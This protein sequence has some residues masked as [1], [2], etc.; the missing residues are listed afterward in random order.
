MKQEVAISH[1]MRFAGKISEVPFS[2]YGDLVRLGDMVV[3]EGRG[4]V[5]WSVEQS[6]PLGVR[7]YG[8]TVFLKNAINWGCDFVLR[9]VCFANR[10]L[11]EELR[12]RD[13]R[14]IF[15]T[16]YPQSQFLHPA[17]YQDLSAS[18]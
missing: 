13:R 17:C 12:F 6:V 7:L 14:P 11:R 8:A 16:R 18:P 9:I 10:M 4:A 2:G 5:R 1:Q 15:R 3:M